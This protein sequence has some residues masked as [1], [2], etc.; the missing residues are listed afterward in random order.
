MQRYLAISI[1]LFLLTAA[2]TAYAWRA[3]EDPT[4]RVA[5]IRRAKPVSA[6]AAEEDQEVEASPTTIE[7][8]L[9]SN[10]NSPSTSNV[11]LADPL[12]QTDSAPTSA[13]LPANYDQIEPSAELKSGTE[14]GSI[15]FS[16][17]IDEAYQAV[18]SRRRFNEGFFTLYGTFAY[19]AMTNG[20]VWS[21]VWKHNGQ[22]V[23]GGNQRWSYGEDGPGYVYFRPE[24]GFQL[25][26]YALEVWVNREMM[27]QASFIVTDDIAAN[28]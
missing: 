19:E 17:E 5:V 28:N 25:G 24:E 9:S 1:V 4:V 16:T 3:P 20:M 23:D 10:P 14:I 26:E 12:L 11:D 22:V 7:I 2:T 15:A 18:D 21:W 6:R 8:N 27:A 13:V